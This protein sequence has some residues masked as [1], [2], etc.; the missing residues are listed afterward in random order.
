MHV[1]SGFI[2]SYLAASF[3]KLNPLLTAVFAFPAVYIIPGLLLL[4]WINGKQLPP[5]RQLIV[6]SFIISTVLNASLIP[7]FTLLSISQ[8]EGHNVFMSLLL[9]TALASSLV[10]NKSTLSSSKL[11]FLII[12]IIMLAYMIMILSL[13]SLPRFFT[14]DE[15]DY[16]SL[17]RAALN[18]EAH[19]MGVTPYRFDFVALISGRFFW[20]FLLASF[21]SSTGLQPCQVYLISPAFLT[22]TALALTLLVPKDLENEGKIHSAVLLLILTSPL[23][24]LFSG[25]GALSDLAI[26]FFASVAVVFFAKSFTITQ[27]KISL[28]VSWLI[29]VLMLVVITLLIKQNLMFL[30]G[31]WL[32]LVYASFRYKLYR[33]N[34]GHKLLLVL[35]IGLPIA[36]ELLIDAPYVMAVWFLRNKAISGFIQPFIFESPLEKILSV[37]ITPWWKTAST[38]LLNQGWINNLDS[39]YTMLTPEGLSL[40]ISALSLVLPAALLLRHVRRNI[41]LRTTILVITTSLI[42][43]Y[44][45]MASS[46]ADIP[47]YTLFI[48]PPLVLLAV[49]SYHEL[50]SNISIHSLLLLSLPMMLFLWI[51][52]ILS[53]AKQGVL[54]GYGIPRLNWTYNIPALILLSYIGLV[55]LLTNVHGLGPSPKSFGRVINRISAKIQWKTT[56]FYVLIL[57]LIFS[58]LY[59][60]YSLV[61]NSES[62]DDH[63]LT[64]IGNVV[65]RY[66]E[67]G[68]VIANNYIYLRPY[69]S[70]KVLFKGIFPA[71]IDENN[72]CDFVKMA[73][74]GTIISIS[75]DQQ[76]S[77]G[78]ANTYINKFS[79][80]DVIT[81]NETSLTKFPRLEYANVV[82]NYTFDQINDTEILDQS[83]FANNG[84]I[85][86]AKVV[87]GYYGNALRFDGA[88]YISA[89]VSQS[90]NVSKEITIDFIGF[91]EQPGRYALVSK[92]YPTNSNASLRGGFYVGASN[93]TLYWE[94]GNG[95]SLSTPIS[96]YFGAWHH[97]IFTYD[98]K[99]M[100]IFVDGLLVA[101]KAQEGD[102]DTTD[103]PLEI[104]RDSARQ[105]HYFDGSIDELIISSYALN[106]TYLASQYHTS[107]ALRIYQ[108][109]FA[110]GQ[111]NLYR[112]VNSVRINDQQSGSTVTKTDIQ[113]NKAEDIIIH[114]EIFSERPAY[115]TTFIGADDGRFLKIYNTTLNAGSN[116]ID[117]WFNYDSPY[118]YRLSL[119]HPKILIL[120]DKGSTVYDGTINKFNVDFIQL[121]FVAA[122]T[123]VICIY[124]L[125]N[126]KYVNRGPRP[127]DHHSN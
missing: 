22:M 63:E 99:S 111:L 36:Y 115:I 42:L 124:L 9:F 82:L 56:S 77:Y 88:S 10:I 78:F 12:L 35:L 101:E 107:Y 119:S 49:I 71:P 55:I 84:M 11:D 41:Q 70:D 125:S 1:T 76:T 83:G 112:I 45:T 44:V 23:L 108:E 80:Q 126:K 5:L 87:E 110:T 29:K 46:I 81:P 20:T 73:P 123:A 79:S 43:Y 32:C 3:L 4:F 116:N 113:S 14:P 58:N 25:I 102:I 2:I 64:S 122:T 98:G 96:E 38:T 85:Y 105:V 6:E 60:S 68:L 50:F 109:D 66:S 21:L 33:S 27:E 91:I 18:G 47:R 90:L 39:L 57:I 106:T 51:N 13:S 89:P 100:R 15:T 52:H 8:T 7:A 72:F 54:L 59:F 74:N 31:M 75:T 114:I 65:T 17:A 26:A 92:G 48:I 103:Y 53:D 24:I 117:Y 30:F 61:S 127:L 104:G 19:T 118:T 28:E 93:Q 120:D 94:L 37:F 69:L 86:G 62:F 121:G 16:I 34:M 97:F 95:W 67:N 40:P